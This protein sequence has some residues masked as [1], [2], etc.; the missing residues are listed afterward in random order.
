VA[1]STPTFIFNEIIPNHQDE[2]EQITLV[3]LTGD[4]K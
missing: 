1:I 3:H 2:V 4:P